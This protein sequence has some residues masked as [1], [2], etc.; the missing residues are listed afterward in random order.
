ML[1]E[2]DELERKFEA[3]LIGGQAIRQGLVPPCYFSLLDEVWRKISQRRASKKGGQ[4]GGQASA[5]AEAAAAAVAAAGEL[6]KTQVGG[7][8]GG[9]ANKRNG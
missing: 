7:M 8:L 3:Q 9:A 2:P 1:Q 4:K 5:A 6:R